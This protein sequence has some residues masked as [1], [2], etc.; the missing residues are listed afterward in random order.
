MTALPVVVADTHALLWH[1]YDP[2]R[3]GTTAREVLRAADEDAARII[4]PAV[5]VAE[6]IMV[7]ERGRLPKVSMAQL[8]GQLARIET[9]SN[10]VLVPLRPA[11][12]IASHQLTAIPD[13]FDRLVVTEAW[14]RGLAL[15]SRD[16]VIAGSGYVATLWA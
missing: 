7:V 9:S 10:Y 3:L 8:Q 4:I 6:M 11:T 13:I 12:V 16:P 2:R 15:L 1:L 5:V 14:E